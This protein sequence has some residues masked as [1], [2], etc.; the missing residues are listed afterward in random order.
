[1]SEAIRVRIETSIFGVPSFDL[2]DFSCQRQFQVASQFGS[3]LVV[4]ISSDFDVKDAQA[5]GGGDSNST[6]FV[7]CLKL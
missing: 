5:I 2:V 3:E 7:I 1:M 6:I 4:K